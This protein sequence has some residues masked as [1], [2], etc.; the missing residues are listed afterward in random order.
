MTMKQLSKAIIAATLLAAGIS[1]SKKSEQ[2]QTVSPQIL[3]QSA[4]KQRQ[5][6]LQ[7]RAF[8]R[9]ASDLAIDSQRG[10]DR[11]VIKNLYLEDQ[12]HEIKGEL[13]T[14]RVQIAILES[15]WESDA[16]YH[17]SQNSLE[18]MLVFL[19]KAESPDVVAALEEP[20]ENVLDAYQTLREANAS[21]NKAAVEKARKRCTEARNVLTTIVSRQQEVIE[22]Q[23]KDAKKQK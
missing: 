5:E 18:K 6:K 7:K 22:Q 1:C 12:L 8:A 21:G 9:E 4:A 19:Q 23:E 17:E 20:Y 13:H 11:A 3:A 15:R 10:A 14:N 16:V 2:P